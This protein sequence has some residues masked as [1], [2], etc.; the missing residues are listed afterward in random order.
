[1]T[2][3][4]SDVV[5]HV[6][7]G[8]FLFVIASTELLVGGAILTMSFALLGTWGALYAYTPEL[9]PTA[10]RATGMGAA[11]AIARLG[12][13]LAPSVMAFLFVQ[14]F[15]LTLALFAT[16]LLLAAILGGLIDVETKRSAL[17]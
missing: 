12:G 15:T 5:S 16:M 9:Y 7:I 2:N 8:C 4:V 11:G 6:K 13:L 1:M 10:S 3:L 14:S 17:A